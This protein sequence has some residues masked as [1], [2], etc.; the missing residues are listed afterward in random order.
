VYNSFADVRASRFCSNDENVS[1]AVYAARRNV[2]DGAG[3]LVRGSAFCGDTSV[4]VDDRY[5]PE[6]VD[7]RHNWWGQNFEPRILGPALTDP[8]LSVDPFFKKREA[9][10]LFFLPGIEAS[11][12]YS[13]ST[14]WVGENQLWEPNRNADV[15]QLFFASS[16][17]PFPHDHVYTR[18]II[19]EVN[20]LGTFAGGS[21]NVYKS[22]IGQFDSLVANGVFSV[23]YPLPYDWR[24]S[25][26]DVALKVL[27]HIRSV[28]DRA[29][30][31]VFV[32]HSN[33]GLV[34]RHLMN[35]MQMAG[36][37]LLAR[38]LKLYFIAVPQEGTPQAALSLLYGHSLALL[39][40]LIL[41]SSVA[42]QL[43][44]TIPGAYGLLPTA[45]LATSLSKQYENH[46]FTFLED[47]FLGS[48]PAGHATREI[49][50]RIRSEQQIIDVPLT[51][52][53]LNIIG[54]GVRTVYGLESFEVVTCKRP[55]IERFYIKDACSP[56]K[57]TIIE[58]L[59]T[60]A[61]DG[62]VLSASARMLSGQ[63]VKT[64]FFDMADYNNQSFTIDRNHSD[65]TEAGPVLTLLKNDLTGIAASIPFLATSS[66]NEV[67]QGGRA[68]MVSVHSPVLID[69]YTADSRHTGRLH[70]P[71]NIE[72]TDTVRYETEI[73]G[74][75]YW[76]IGDSKY[77]LLPE[78]ALADGIHLEFRG[79]GAG[80]ATLVFEYIDGDEPVWR[81]IVEDVPTVPALQ[82]SMTVDAS[83]LSVSDATDKLI[84]TTTFPNGVMATST[85]AD[86]ATSTDAAILRYGPTA[87]CRSRKTG[88]LEP[89]QVKR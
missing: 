61:G 6:Q 47:S 62:T 23:W 29:D 87:Y 69:A 63:Q 80:L 55:S 73:P 16:G 28:S 82:S 30:R 36:D 74:S 40:G 34:L 49:L 71:V 78:S 8:W 51:V 52:P 56:G 77:I 27:Q 13:T 3:A 7:V 50:E 68:F 42:Q 10:M 32:A 37:P 53:A 64:V 9:T 15:S 75:A 83:V 79:V 86:L 60:V 81:R 24:F 25:A 44:E 20:S 22:L 48:R 26:R 5:L 19:D 57:K 2:F 72:T 70:H 54:E 46:N 38:V 66:L 67:T 12:L 35:L 89:R 31:I 21:Q 43:A 11:R 76:E 85:L 84:A 39:G 65:I 14:F 17:L 33:G 58:P 4:Y 41:K 59:T 1:L 18:D 45:T 88:E